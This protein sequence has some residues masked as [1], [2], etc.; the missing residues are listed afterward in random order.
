M[1]LIEAIVDANQR[2]RAGDRPAAFRAEEFADSLPLV[3]L[4][5]I[6]V[7]LNSFLPEMLGIRKEQLIWLRNAGNII[8]SPSSSTMRS[9]ALACAVKGGREIA[10]IGHNDCK[11]RQTSVAELIDRFR[12]LGV[13]RSRLP[14]NLNDFFGLF[15]SERQN[16][17]RGVEFIRQ[18]PLIGAKV[19]AHGLLMDIETGKLEWLVNGYEALGRA[20]SE[21]APPSSALLDKLPAFQLGEMKFPDFKI[22]EGAAPTTP[23]VQPVVVPMSEPEVPT[24]AG[25][26]FNK[27]SLFKIVGSDNKVYGPVNGGEVEAWLADDRVKP[28]SLAQKV[29]GKEWK[30][31]ASFAENKLSTAM[32]QPPPLPSGF[33]ARKT[34]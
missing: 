7:R 26:K 4:T 6:D 22:G 2:A 17:I 14:D 18:S 32:R 30:P 16:V 25:L 8:T 24:P 12:A 19:P 1:R 31:L 21:V 15:A 3:A 11:V 34:K 20:G 9:L 5:C 33:S 29:G 23:S 13:E 28:S 27:N 10:L